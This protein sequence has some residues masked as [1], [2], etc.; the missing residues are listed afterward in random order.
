MIF[1]LLAIGF[2]VVFIP[3]AFIDVALDMGSR[4]R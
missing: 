2:V 4:M 3:F 1:G